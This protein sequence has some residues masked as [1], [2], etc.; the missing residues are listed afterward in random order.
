[1]APMISNHLAQGLHVPLETFKT[2]VVL[3]AV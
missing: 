2:V 3:F 1:M